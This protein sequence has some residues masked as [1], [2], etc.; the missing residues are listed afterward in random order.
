MSEGRRNRGNDTTLHNILQWKKTK[1]GGP[2]IKGTG[3]GKIERLSSPPSPLSHSRKCK[4]AGISNV[5]DFK[6]HVWKTVFLCCD[7]EKVS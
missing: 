7:P 6:F 4:N 5:L 3:G 1:G 2:E